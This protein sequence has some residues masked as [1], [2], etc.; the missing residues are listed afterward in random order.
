MA[1]RARREGTF[2]GWY[3]ALALFF[4]IFLSVGLR[5]GYGVFVSTWQEDFSASVATVSIAAAVGWLLNGLSQPIFGRITDVMGGRGVILVSLLVMGGGSVAMAAVPNVYVLI[6]LYG[7]IISFATGGVSFTPAGVIVARWFRRK[8][9]VAISL[10]TTGG[11]AGGLVLVPFAAYLLAFSNWRTAWLVMGLLILGLAVPLIALVVRSDP[12][13]MGLQPDG[14]DAPASGDTAGAGMPKGPLEAKRWRDSLSS[15]PMW[16]LSVAYVVCGVTTASI[17]V[18]FVRWAESESISAGTA[19]I[20]FGVLSGINGLSVV[21]VGLLSDRMPRRVL[22]GGVYL[23]RAFAFLALVFLPGQAALWSFAIIGGMS[24]LATVPLTTALAA[25]VYGV[26]H[27]GV[28]AGLIN[29]THQMGGAAAVYVFGLV[30]D[31]YNT[32]DPAYLAGAALLVLAAIT[33]LSIKERKYSARYAPVTA[34]GVTAT[35]E[36]LGP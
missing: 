2:Y 14:D 27:L 16:Q 34:T 18:H 4:S 28:L 35:G 32:Y 8:R 21:A 5:Q 31:R 10:L 17:A 15:P 19:A 25:D 24:W 11:S 13:E 1:R 29:M 30:F 22:L 7:F 26:R 20:A 36:S 23:I 9:G 12:S 33:A 3:V 6:G